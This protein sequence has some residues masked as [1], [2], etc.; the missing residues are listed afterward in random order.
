[1]FFHVK[2]VAFWLGTTV[3]A[4]MA[5]STIM[6]WNQWDGFARELLIRRRSFQGLPVRSGEIA[7]LQAILPEVLVAFLGVTILVMF[8][9]RKKLQ[10]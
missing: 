1:M 4:L 3:A 5:V 6:C 10:S 7:F 8:L 9:V 2:R